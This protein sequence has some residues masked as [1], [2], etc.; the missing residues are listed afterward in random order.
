MEKLDA[1][2]F[3]PRSV[4]AKEI[5]IRQTDDEFMFPIADGIAKLPGKDYE[6]R[7]P[8][9]RRE[10]TVR[11]QDLSGEFKAKRESLNRQ[12]Q[13]MTLKPVPTSGRSKV[14]SSVVTT[15]NLEFISTCRRKK[16][17]LSHSIF[18]MLQGLLIL[19]CVTRIDDYWNVDSSIH[20]SDSWT[21]DRETICGQG[22]D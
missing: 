12:N 10:P 16:H 19:I 11:S 21:T 18:F 17:S 2:D 7:V 9:L 14:T 22:S 8:T 15:M 5:P 3:Y 1:S 6:F 20:L 13:Q 4:N